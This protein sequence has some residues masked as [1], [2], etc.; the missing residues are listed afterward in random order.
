M[1]LFVVLL[2]LLLAARIFGEAAHRLGQ[3]ALL[4]EIIAG[5]L[6]GVILG[7]VEVVPGL[8]HLT[9]DPKF[10]ALADLG[11]F[12]LMLYGGVQLRPGELAEV[13]ARSSVVA[14][15]G[16][17]LPFG[18]GFGVAWLFLPASDFKVAQ[19]V[20]IGTALSITAVPASIRVLIDLGQLESAA[21]KVI[22]AAAIIDDVLSLILLSFL[23]GLISSDGPPG[24]T[25]MLRLSGSVVLFLGISVLLLR[26]VV[27][28]IGSF[29]SRFRTAEFQFSSL[30][31][32]GLTL[33]VLAEALG[34]HFILGAFTAGIL[35]DRRHT[36]P[37]VYKEVERRVSAVTLGFLAPIFFASVGMHLDLGAVTSSPLF[38]LVLVVVAIFTKLVGAGVP[39]LAMGLSRRDSVAVGVGMSARGAVELIVA[40]MALRGGLF[41]R[42]DPPPAIVTDMYSSIV[43]VAI[44]TTL[45][46]PMTLKKIFGGGATTDTRSE[47]VRTER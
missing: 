47:K 36:R 20:F 43:I 46:A 27:P 30:L 7:H 40:E 3:P 16:M 37:A 24:W 15:G 38:L 28:R 1:E 19:C 39:A 32:A 29:V 33:A 4:G 9:D 31:I 34:L 8:M 25:S 5:I 14:I 42:P 6:L 17:V 11:I 10:V 45:I 35:F 13:S 21:G 23:A 41:T 22:V 26:I 44:V 12:F 18:V 2:V